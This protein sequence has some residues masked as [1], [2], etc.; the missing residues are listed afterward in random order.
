MTDD[1]AL[2]AFLE[3][4]RTAGT[5]VVMVGDPRQLSAVGP[6]GGFEALVFRFGGSVHVLSEN[7]RQIDP[8]EREALANLRS[9]HVGAAVA[10]YAANGRITVSPDRDTALDETVARW[11]AD[12]RVGAA[13][14]M[15]A[16]QRASVAELNRRGRLAW[17]ELG[18]LSGPELVVGNV[19]Y[20]TGDRVVTLAPG[21]GGEIVTSECGT[22]LAVDVARRELGVTMDDGRY[23]RFAGDDLAQD[24]LTHGYA[25]TGHRSQGATVR[26]AQ[27]LEDGGGRELA[28]VKMSRA[29]ESTTVHTVAD[30]LEQAVEDLTRAWSHSRRIGWAI[31]QG[32]PA[33]D[34]PKQRANQVEPPESHSLR[35]ARLVAEREALVAALPSDPG[36]S[37]GQAVACVQ[38]L[39]DERDALIHADGR[40][41]L[42]GTPVGDAALA[43]S[44]VVDEWGRYMAQAEH[45]GLRE[46]HQL[47][48]QGA[49]ALKREGP[50]RDAFNALAGPERD[51]IRAEL[52]EAER[53]LAELAGQRDASA[54]FS[55]AHPEAL[56]RLIQLGRDIDAAA[57]DM[58]RER[59]PLDG[60]APHRPEVPQLDRRFQRDDRVLER[61]IELDRGFGL[62][63]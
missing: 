6:G 63:L 33:P 53:K 28:Y 7:V 10:W 58:D 32:V 35:H 21:A 9:G 13:P 38:R 40:G 22:V 45:A 55:R 48:R 34:A 15:Y 31:D 11:V 47:H 25:V 50:L 19:G 56:P 4:A 42:R 16:W 12:V 60:I 46:R 17:E 29:W 37:Y 26:R 14:A 27:S 61:T 43:L 49:K 1:A 62:E 2:L 57:Y 30:S 36:P 52:P 51:R 59:E 20:R 44:R 23:Q 24:H 3:S 54:N 18:R 41:V 5:K 8:T 39:K